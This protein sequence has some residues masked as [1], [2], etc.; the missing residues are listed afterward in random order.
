MAVS[1]I[2]S[3][4][5]EPAKQGIRWIFSRQINTAL[6]RAFGL[7]NVCTGSDFEPTELF[8]CLFLASLNPPGVLLTPLVSFRAVMPLGV[9]FSPPGVIDRPLV[10]SG[11]PSNS[12]N[13]AFFE[14][15]S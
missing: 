10:I 15:R 13:D 14:E 9:G 11:E 2:K 1:R 4:G 5:I 6:D 12:R 7:R 3:K 8:F